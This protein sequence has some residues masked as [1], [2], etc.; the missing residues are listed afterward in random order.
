VIFPHFESEPVPYFHVRLQDAFWAPRQRLLAT[1]SVP[2]ATRHLD[3]AGGLDAFRADP[4][5]YE[6]KLRRGDFEA[7]KFVEALAAVVGLE[8]DEAIE[9]LTA[10]WGRAM[11]D[12]QAADGYF[13]FGWPLGADPAK[14]WRASWISHEDYGLGHYIEAA[15][16][17]LESTGE[18]A[19]YESAVRAVG[20]MA[21]ALLDGERAYAP[22]HAAIEQGLTRLYGFTG[23]TKY[24]DLCGWL[25]E[26]RGNHEGRPSYGR[27]A[28][29]HLPV[30]EQRT[31]EGHAVRAAFLFNGVTEYVGAT[32]DEGYFKAVLAVW[33]D[34]VQ[35]K[36]YV[37]G[38]GGNTSTKNEGYSPTP[39]FIPPDDAY[40]E[41]CSAFANFQWAHNLFR[42]T[43]DASYIDV[44]ERT[45]YNAFYASLSLSGDRFFYR[46]VIQ[47]FEPAMR[48][49][50][51]W[52]PCCPPNIVKLLAKVGGFFYSTDDDGIF[53][54]HYGAS[55]ADLP[56]GGGIKLT[57]RTEYPWDGDVQLQVDPQT[58]TE[59]TLR[60]R[61]PSWAK[62]HD[63]S[64]N[65]ELVE[66]DVQAGWVSIRRSWET[67]DTVRLSLPMTIERVSMPPRFEEYRDLAALERG[68]IVYCVEQQDA[69][70]P[71]PALCLA[72]DVRVTAEHRPDLLGGVTVLE[73]T[74]PASSD[75]FDSP[76]MPVTFIPY[77]V[78]NNRKPDFMTVWLP[79]KRRSLDEFDA[80]PG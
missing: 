14:R 57:Q 24:L 33:E 49:E 77:G 9:G 55:E 4:E 41:S 48:T 68:P 72:E 2:W 59:L 5:G 1:V 52:C 66:T 73:T 71:L 79:A 13:E 27:Y 16:G 40:C 43:G 19:M 12:G 80:P 54:K 3:P 65:G 67:G 45:L 6:T 38:T 10:A 36:M 50:W 46:N 78:W 26:Q 63:L 32:G 35:H 17:Y 70:G 69:A 44:A 11:I 60:L 20:N 51:H 29:D 30:R 25:I 39:D 74:L 34:F 21:S 7:I 15:I 56:F 76:P 58:P 28:Q 61:I 18:S 53:V 42:L 23:D 31:I 64:V 62:S 75:L 22:G 47:A 37:H 8:R